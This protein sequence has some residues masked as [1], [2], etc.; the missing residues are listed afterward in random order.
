VPPFV[1]VRQNIEQTLFTFGVAEVANKHKGV[2]G[3]WGRQTRHL[4]TLSLNFLK[5]VTTEKWSIR[6]SLSTSKMK[7]IAK[8]TLYFLC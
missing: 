7:C 4:K 3:G 6:N 2:L 8:Y 1:T 5:R